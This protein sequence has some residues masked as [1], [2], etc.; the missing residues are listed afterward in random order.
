VRPARIALL[1]LPAF[2]LACQGEEPG[3]V[4]ASIARVTLGVDPAQADALADLDVTVELQ[5]RGQAEEVTLSSATITA[6]PVTDDSDSLAFAAHMV[7]TQGADPIVRIA[8]HETVV[9][10]VLNDGTT[11]GD[12]ATWCRLPVELEI[13]VETADGEEATTTADVSVRCP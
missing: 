10:R 5:A 4:E 11:N 12:L 1:L 7:N 2:L 13:V 9:V 3:G 8:I 6:Q